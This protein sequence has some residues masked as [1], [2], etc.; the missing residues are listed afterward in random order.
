LTL[1]LAEKIRTN[2]LPYLLLL[3]R[4]RSESIRK[5]IADIE[6]GTEIRPSDIKEI[7][8]KT[9]E[10]KVLDNT[11]KSIQGFAKKAEEELNVLK[12]N[13]GTQTLAYVVKAQTELF[14]ESVHML[15]T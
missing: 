8:K 15:N 3:A 10:T 4:E 2:N 9:I 14:I 11:I 7:V 5:K 12:R 6:Y 1:E 13:K